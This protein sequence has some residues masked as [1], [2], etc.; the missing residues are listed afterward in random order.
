MTCSNC[1]SQIELLRRFCGQCAAR[2][3][4]DCVRCGF[5]NG[6]TDG[7]CGGC[8]AALHLV[9]VESGNSPP[10][11]SACT[12]AE[13]GGREALSS[14]DLEELLRKPVTPAAPALS[15]KVSQNELDQLF[16]AGE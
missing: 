9:G 12:P 11:Q 13:H 15:S 2:V 14:S 4:T 6:L 16:G 3:R 5:L 10:A 1:G 8:S 7:Y